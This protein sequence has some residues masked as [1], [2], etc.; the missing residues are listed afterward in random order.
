M[1]QFIEDVLWELAT[2]KLIRREAES[3]GG[4]V[5]TI[6]G[7]FLEVPGQPVAEEPSE[8]P[9][10]KRAGKKTRPGS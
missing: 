9:D 8:N 3:S 4:I 7:R 6:E 5:R 10:R 2:G 1:V